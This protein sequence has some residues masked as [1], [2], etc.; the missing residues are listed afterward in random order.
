MQLPCN[1]AYSGQCARKTQGKHDHENDDR[2][3]IVYPDKRRRNLSRPREREYEHKP[4]S[5]DLEYVQ[6]SQYTMPFYRIIEACN[7]CFVKKV[8]E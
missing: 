3:Q 2:P 4:Q 1:P 8:E 7:V 6:S 5:L